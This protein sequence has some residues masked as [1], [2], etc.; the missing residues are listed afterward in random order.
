MPKYVPDTSKKA[1]P[2]V[3][4]YCTV[5][6][7][8]NKYSVPCKYRGKSTTVKGYPNHVEVWVDG[9]M[10]AKHERL[11]G[12]QCESLDL[13][14]Y[15]P[16][17]AQK[18]RAIRYA[19]PVRNAVPIEFVDWMENQNLKAKEMVEKLEMCLEYGY[20]AV[21]TGDIPASKANP[22]SDSVTVSTVDLSQYDILCR[23]E[24]AIS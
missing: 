5:I 7:D 2:D 6:F 15:L 16:I 20:E 10:I 14:H 8:K 22:I 12:T 9:K 4:R 11:F 13:R 3:N 19:K 18:G 23:K 17:L 21:M 24:A 1:F